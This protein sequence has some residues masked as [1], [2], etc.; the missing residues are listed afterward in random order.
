M[1]IYSTRLYSC[2]KMNILE[3][4]NELIYGDRAVAYGPVSE[5]FGRIAR[6]WSVILDKEVT[7]EQVGLC[8]VALKMS[9]QISKAG[10]GNL[11][12]GAG[13]FGCIAKMEEEKS[14]QS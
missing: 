11:V 3:E 10:R 7:A 1:G 5:S 9:R 13:Y 2:Y 14:Q 4:A 8:M 12:D 6:F